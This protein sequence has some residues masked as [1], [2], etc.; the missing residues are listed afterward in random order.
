MLQVPGVTSVERAMPACASVLFDFDASL[1]DSPEPDRAQLCYGVTRDLDTSHLPMNQ[2]H[3]NQ[4]LVEMTFWTEKHPVG[5][6]SL[7][8]EIHA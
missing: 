3:I 7:T 5:F 6:H 4:A 8:L 1:L 2:P